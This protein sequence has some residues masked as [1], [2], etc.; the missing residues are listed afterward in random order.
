ME[1]AAD[2]RLR[3]HIEKLCSNGEDEQRML[4]QVLYDPFTCTPFSSLALFHNH[5]QRHL[6]EYH[7]QDEH[8][9]TDDHIWTCHHG[10]RVATEKMSAPPTNGP[11]I[12][13]RPLNDWAKLILAEQ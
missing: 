3:S 10:K 9:Q 13:P 2:A 11:S 7:R 5:R 4:Q 6:D 12:H 8:H 1:E